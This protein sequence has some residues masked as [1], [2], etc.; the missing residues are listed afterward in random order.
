MTILDVIAMDRETVMQV[1]GSGF[2]DFEDAFQS[3]AA[4]QSGVIDVI[5]T[6]NVKDYSK[7]EMGV[8][9]PEAYLKT[10]SFLH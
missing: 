8:L 10:I 9:T 5:L 1:L 4:N 2:K 7:S 6:R 3:F